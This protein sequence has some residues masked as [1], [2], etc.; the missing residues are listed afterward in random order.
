[1]PRFSDESFSEL[2]KCHIELQTLFYEVVKHFDCTVLEGYRNEHDQEAAFQR[3]TTTLHYPFGKHNQVPSMAADVA[4]YPVNFS[5]RPTNI[6]RFY[7]F[8]GYVMGIAQR[9][10][11]E[12]KMVHAI[13][14]GGDWDADKDLSDQKLNDLL[15]FELVL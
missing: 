1:M 7:L 11:D 12:G 15:H 3:G 5:E 8:A 14:W 4:P 6:A 2:S 10:R 13:R 9:L